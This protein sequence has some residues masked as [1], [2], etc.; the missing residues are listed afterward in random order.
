MKK[1]LNNI[2]HTSLVSYYA[3]MA[4]NTGM[5]GTMKIYI[6]EKLCVKASGTLSSK[7]FIAIKQHVLKPMTT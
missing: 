6:L 1:E 2:P 7:N 3:N 4:P 5:C